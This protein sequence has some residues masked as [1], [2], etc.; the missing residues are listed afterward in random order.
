MACQGIWTFPE[1]SADYAHA[2][3]EGTVQKVIDW[4]HGLDPFFAVMTPEQI[5]R[6]IWFK[7]ATKKN[8]EN[9]TGKTMTRHNCEQVCAFIVSKDHAATKAITAAK[10]TSPMFYSMITLPIKGMKIVRLN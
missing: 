2:L 9:I 8:M 4:E 5:T 7:H 6:G 1:Q 3:P 10:G